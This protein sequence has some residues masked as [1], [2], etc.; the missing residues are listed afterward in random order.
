MT[1]LEDWQLE[2]IEDTLR[3][4]SNMIKAPE[5][6][7]CLKRMVMLSWN[8]VVD[9]LNDV[10]KNVTSENGIKYRMEVN[11]TPKLKKYEDNK[12]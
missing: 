4:V 10:P 11:Q 1:N 5:R 8:W 9:A 2:E 3:L 7:T 6:D 12:H